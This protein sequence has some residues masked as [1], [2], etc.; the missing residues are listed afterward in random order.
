MTIP[1]GGGAGKV[2]LLDPGGLVREITFLVL[3]GS[4]VTIPGLGWEGRKEGVCR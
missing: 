3:V 1:G 2:T 4:P